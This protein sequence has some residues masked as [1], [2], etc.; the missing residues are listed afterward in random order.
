MKI[1]NI[2]NLSGGIT[3]VLTEIKRLLGNSMN[4]CITNKL[5]T[6]E[7]MNKYFK[8][9]TKVTQEENKI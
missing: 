5:D 3:T 7:E 1:N 6:L 9:S 2:S 4:N 8:I